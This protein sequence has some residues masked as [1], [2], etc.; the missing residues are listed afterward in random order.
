VNKY[1]TEWTDKHVLTV[2]FPNVKSKW[3]QWV[4]LMGDTHWDSKYT[5]RG[6]M[7]ED[8]QE[9]KH[10]KALILHVGDVFDLMQGR[11]DPRREYEDMRPELMPERDKGYFNKVIEQSVEFFEPFAENFLLIGMGNHEATFL[12]NNGINPIWDLTSRMKVEMGAYSGWVQ[13]R[14]IEKSGRTNC[15]PLYYHHGWGGGAPVTGG[16]ID[17][18][19]VAEWMPDARVVVMGHKHSEYVL[20]KK[21]V[22]LSERGVE[23]QDTQWHV[24]VPSYLNEFGTGG[25]GTQKGFGPKTQGCVWLRMFYYGKGVHLDFTQGD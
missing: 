19:R 14:T 8:L 15:I 21:R 4:C 12:K 17:T 18:A 20:P 22:R 9:A 6:K 10:R 5:D 13:F 1:N 25:W 3:E 2:R 7:L 16:V 11:Y 24:R 23:H